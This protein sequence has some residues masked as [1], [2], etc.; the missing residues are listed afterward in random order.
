MSLSKITLS[1]LLSVAVSGCSG[2]NNRMSSS[3]FL[4]IS[5]LKTRTGQEFRVMHALQESDLPAWNASEKALVEF[6]DYWDSHGVKFGNAKLSVVVMPDPKIPKSEVLAQLYGN[7]FMRAAAEYQKRIEGAQ[8]VAEIR[9]VAREAFCEYPPVLA[10]VVSAEE[11]VGLEKVR[12]K[13]LNSLN[14]LIDIT[15]TELPGFKPDNAFAGYLP[16]GQCGAIVLGRSTDLSKKFDAFGAQDIVQHEMGHVFH[17]LIW[18]AKSVISYKQLSMSL[19]EAVADIFAHSYSGDYCH[20]KLPMVN[21][22]TGENC[23]RVMNKHSA[24]LRQSVVEN[25]SDGHNN[26]QALRHFLWNLRSEVGQELFAPAFV[27][28][29]SDVTAV[30]A[31]NKPASRLTVG[32]F[33]TEA[34]NIQRNLLPMEAFI[35]AMC[36]RLSAARVCLNPSE[37]LGLD[38]SSKL[39]RLQENAPSKRF[40]VWQSQVVN[41][42][43]VSFRFV[44]NAEQGRVN[45]EVKNASGNTVTY[46]ENGADFSNGTITLSF[47]NPAEPFQYALW[48]EYGTLTLQ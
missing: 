18:N 42:A 6:V 24:P 12:A 7:D 29:L 43:L 4:G 25:S 33:E 2:I 5:N 11:S 16:E 28:A 46:N 26:N 40:E 32:F 39:T 8:N 9:A 27:G 13:A 45:M 47:Y 3:Q 38:V 17:G 37:F 19:N 36:Q 44:L 21:P 34:D 31:A 23:S 14:V 48:S 30:L 1:L 10:G 41:G 35:N 15:R 22:D 20:G